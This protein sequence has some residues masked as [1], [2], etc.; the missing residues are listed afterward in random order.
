[1]KKTIIISAIALFASLYALNARADFNSI[2]TNHMVDSPK[3]SPFCMAIVKGDFE[4]V[5]KM[6]ELGA[7]V[8]ER[9]A[10][11]TPAMYAARYNK[12]DILKLLITNGADL[13]EKSKSGYA[14][15]DYAWLSKAFEAK[16][17]IEKALAKDSKA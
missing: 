10:G 15:K 1:M 11:L 8:N 6:I 3:V 16:E 5:K 7:D 9:S 2:A 12:V 17:V 13:N 14:A 4:T